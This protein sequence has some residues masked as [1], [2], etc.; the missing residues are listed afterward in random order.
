M[1]AFILG[2]MAFAL[3]ACSNSNSNPVQWSESTQMETTMEPT[4]FYDLEATTIDGEPFSFEQLRG[5]RVLIVN[6]A[7]ECGFTPQYK[8]LQELH[9]TYGSDQFIL[10]G[11]PS[12]DFGGQEPGTESEIASFCQRNY[13]VDFQMMSKVVT[14]GKKG[15]PVYQ[16]LCTKERNGK[17]DAKV[18]WN[19]NKFL[20]DADGNWVAHLG[21]RTKPMSDE[22][23]AFAKGEN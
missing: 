1:K 11:F 9:A 13:G 22:I 8:E 19:F 14:D 4:S 21:S 5:K 7:S 23:V 18:S 3:I 2:S 20:I 16:W 15:H 17:D 6:T 12:N 10:L